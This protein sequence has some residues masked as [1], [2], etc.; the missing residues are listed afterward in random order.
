MTKKNEDFKTISKDFDRFLVAKSIPKSPVLIKCLSVLMAFVLVIVL[1]KMFLKEPSNK[2]HE[3]ILETEIGSVF[4]ELKD[5]EGDSLNRSLDRQYLSD[6][7]D[8]RFQWVSEDFDQLVIREDS[9]GTTI[10]SII[11]HY[12]KP[13][14]ISQYDNN[15][16]IFA[17]L[18]YEKA[19]TVT[20]SFERFEDKQLHLVSAHFYGF[21]P[22]EKYGITFNDNGK[23]MTQ[24][25][26]HEIEKTVGQDDGDI[27]KEL[28]T[29]IE[30]PGTVN[31]DIFQSGSLRRDYLWLDYPFDFY[32]TRTF[33]FER[34]SNGEFVLVA[35]SNSMNP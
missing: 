17:Y 27:L 13:N 31:F 12:G 23:K 20:L 21:R 4:Q 6:P 18:A 33:Q 32:E 11:K 14:H 9:K 19:Q 10:D 28:M 30:P 29:D 24:E 7:E 25:L 35:A 3:K 22:P 26:F 16:I 2:K 1:V 5:I 15:A 34:K 8:F